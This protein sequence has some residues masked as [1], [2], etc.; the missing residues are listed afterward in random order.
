[1]VEKPISIAGQEVE[2]DEEEIS[3][4]SDDEI[5]PIKRKESEIA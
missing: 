4:I 5:R 1:M 3:L 2:I